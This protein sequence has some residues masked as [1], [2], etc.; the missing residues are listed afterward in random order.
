VRQQVI[1]DNMTVIGWGLETKG[2]GNSRKR[3]IA[4]ARN[5]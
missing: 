3:M 2:E 1:A 5:V 4:T